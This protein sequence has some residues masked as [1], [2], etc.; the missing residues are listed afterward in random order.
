MP[1]NVQIYPNPGGFPLSGDV[2]STPG[3]STVTVTGIQTE[4]VSSVTPAEGDVLQFL[5]G[6]WTPA[7]LDAI[8][9]KGSVSGSGTTKQVFINGVS[10]G[11]PSWGIDIN[12]SAD[13]G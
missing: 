13:G 9:V 11:A 7:F 10:D 6:E 4:P 5:A 1:S 2:V 3:S 8:L 12:G